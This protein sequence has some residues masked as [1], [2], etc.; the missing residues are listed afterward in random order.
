MHTFTDSASLSQEEHIS[1]E[2]NPAKHPNIIF[3]LADDL[4]YGDVGYNGGFSSTPNIDEMARGPHSI[5]FNQFY[6]GSPVCSP[7]RGTLLTGRNHNRYCV[8]AANTKGRSCNSP[9]D[10]MCP[11]QFPL[12]L[13]EITIAEILKEQGYRTAVFGKWHLGDLKPLSLSNAHPSSNPGQNGFDVW[14]V[15]ERA[16][17]T[18]TPNCGCFNISQCILG[19]Y[20]ESEEIIPCTNYYS[21][22][23]PAE[24]TLTAVP[25]DSLIVQ[26]DSNFI[27]DQLLSFITNTTTSSDQP[28]FAYVPFHAV[29]KKYIATPPYNLQYLSEFLSN[30]EI[31]YFGAISAMDSAIGR[32]R[33]ALEDLGISSNTMIWFAS[34]NGPAPKSPGNAS[35]LRGS[36]GTLYEGGI[37]VP[38][39]IEWPKTVRGNRQIDTPVVTNDFLPTICDVLGISPP[40]D[41]PLDGES[42][43][44]LLSEESQTTTTWQRNSSIKWAFKIKGKFGGKYRLAVI[45]N[46]NFKLLAK[47]QHERVTGAELYDL[48]NDPGESIDVS[49]QNE[50]MFK[51]LLREAESWRLSVKDSAINKVRCHTEL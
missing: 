6:S 11:T 51:E 14:E 39:I 8:W 4:G 27:I 37:R 33:T 34:D 18:A 36:K 5:Q 15:T 12:P 40:T 46:G 30:E 38:G 28:F 31:D 17:P 1:S 24:D 35:G 21:A 9:D 41:R 44:P 16:V 47:Y 50:Q 20:E 42:I 25:H 26:D 29:H 43:L 13:S 19:H 45:N 3:L 49:L 2:L 7:T 48:T 10:F 32:L 22:Q 23:T